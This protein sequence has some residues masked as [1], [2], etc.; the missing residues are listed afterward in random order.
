MAAGVVA[1]ELGPVHIVAVASPGYMKARGAPQTPQDLASF[2]CIMRRS[3][4][5][6]IARRRSYGNRGRFGRSRSE[7]ASYT[8]RRFQFAAVAKPWA[9]APLGAGA[10]PSL[11]VIA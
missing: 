6:K 2:D 4:P 1:R 8:A 10:V 9:R 11:L 3:T 7:D 5:A